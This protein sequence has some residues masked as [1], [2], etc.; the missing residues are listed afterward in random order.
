MV[1]GAELAEEI[2]AHFYDLD[3]ALV[4]HLIHRLSHLDNVNLFRASDVL[5]RA[6]R[7]IQ[8]NDIQKMKLLALMSRI[9]WQHHPG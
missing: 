4:L 6:V 5:H 2:V 8:S 1:C 3:Y 7:T 9:D